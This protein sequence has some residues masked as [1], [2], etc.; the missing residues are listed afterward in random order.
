MSKLKV[1][2]PGLV[3]LSLL[4]MPMVASALA[5]PGTGDEGLTLSEIEDLIDTVA[6]FIITIGIIIVVIAIV[7]AGIQF[8]TAGG[9]TTKQENAKSWLKNGI[10]AAL[11]VLG[12]GVLLNTASN[13]VTRSFFG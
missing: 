4:A 13:V 10:I 11:I 7:W 6:N 12:V 1:Y 5:T 9:D 8:A 2:L 3:L